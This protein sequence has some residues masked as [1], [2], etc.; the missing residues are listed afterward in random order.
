MGPNDHEYL[1]QQ[2]H[3]RRKE[4]GRR[5]LT[6]ALFLV[7]VIVVVIL[8]VV[9]AGN[10]G[11]SNSTSTTQAGSS[12][13]S[14]SV[15]T[16]GSGETTTSSMSAG[17][18]AVTYTADLGGG[19]EIPP[20]STAAGGTLTLTVAA[21]GSSVDYVLELTSIISPTVARLHEGKVGASG[22]TIFTVYGGPVKSGLYSGTIARGSFTAADLVGPLKGKTLDDLVG[23]IEAESVYLNVGTESNHTGEIRGQVQ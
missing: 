10:R 2:D 21:D 8:A 20:V 22:P 9:L 12:A 11:T 1:P 23:M 6:L 15:S 14:T 4:A 7:V 18:Q 5:R 13:S 16:T 17:P 3:R 19:N